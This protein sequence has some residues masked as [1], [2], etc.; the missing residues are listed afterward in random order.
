MIYPDNIAAAILKMPA[1][2]QKEIP[3]ILDEYMA[4]FSSS[5]DPDLEKRLTSKYPYKSVRD[6]VFDLKSRPDTTA[7]GSTEPLDPTLYTPS[8]ISAM[9]DRVRKYGIC[10]TKLDAAKGIVIVDT[11][12]IPTEF[13]VPPVITQPQVSKKSTK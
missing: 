1:S 12:D 4:K 8:I 6:R 11:T 5:P 9:T 2:Q 13:P 10:V 3:Q 7:A